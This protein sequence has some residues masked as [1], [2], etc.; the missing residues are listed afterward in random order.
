MT[1]GKKVWWLGLALAVMLSAGCA[2]ILTQL[3]HEDGTEERLRVQ[4][5]ERWSNWDHNSRREDGFGLML[6]KESTF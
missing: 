2:G 5:G 1:G 3:Y 6:K 4:S